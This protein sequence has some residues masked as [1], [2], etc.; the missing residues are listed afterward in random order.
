MSD[1]VMQESAVLSCRNLGK[2]Y[3]EG[4]ESV[5]VLSGLQ[6][7]MF[8]GE[9]VAI[10]GTGAT[11]VQCVP[12]LARDAKELL[13]FQRTPSSVDERNNAPI[14]PEERA[15]MAT[16]LGRA[17]EAI[18][19]H[20]EA[21]NAARGELVKL[22]DLKTALDKGKVLGACLDVLENEK[23]ATF[24]SAEKATHQA[25]V[26]SGKVLFS[27]HVAGWTVESYRKISEVLAAKI[28]GW[29]KG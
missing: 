26:D 19:S 13:V 24:T 23:P 18:A 29:F 20:G 22:A 14:D 21:I 11:S 27:P 3:D 17:G 5:V 12:H 2:S 4:P 15:K 25:L 1:Q 28:E 7:E 10:I 9:R 6:L 16:P 8:P